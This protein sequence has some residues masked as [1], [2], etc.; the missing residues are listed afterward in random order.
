VTLWARTLADDDPNRYL[1][2]RGAS[3]TGALPYGISDLLPTFARDESREL[4]P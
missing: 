1:Y 3:R 4:I 2:L